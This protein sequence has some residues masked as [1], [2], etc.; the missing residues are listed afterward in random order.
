MSCLYSNLESMVFLMQFSQWKMDQVNITVVFETLDKDRI[1]RD[2]VRNAFKG[3][4]QE[5]IITDFPDVLIVILPAL[6]VNANYSN[7]RLH[8]N[9]P[10]NN[11]EEAGELLAQACIDL[12]EAVPEATTVAYGYNLNGKCAVEGVDN[13]NK[14]LLEVCYGGGQSLAKAI[15]SEIIAVSPNFSFIK[16]DAKFNVSLKPFEDRQNYLEFHCNIHFE[17]GEVP[18]KDKIKMQ[19]VEYVNLFKGIL[20]I[21]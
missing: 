18:G 17:N 19:F 5:V 12:I 3:Q 15:D 10:C 8:I 1:R 2:M 7:R 6:N 13:I 21:L 9:L 16:Y 20:E 4:E 14:Y 11:I